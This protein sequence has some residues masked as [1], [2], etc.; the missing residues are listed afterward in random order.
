MIPTTTYLFQSERLG[1][2]NWLEP[3]IEKMAEINADPVVMEFFPAIQTESQTKEFID[4][5]QKQHTEK[6]FC[7]FAVDRLDKREFIGFIGLSEQTFE[8][9]F[10]PCID[11]GWRL[12]RD[13]WY[14]GFATEG[15]KRCIEYAFDD[16]GIKKLVAIAPAIN[17]KS[18]GVMVKIGMTKLG[19]FNHPK[20]KDNERLENCVIYELMPPNA[21]TKQY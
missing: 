18:E 3:D 4:K 1:F 10:S 11:I 7:Y 6:G 9:D 2:R 5:M 15:A 21:F 16:L 20:L 14:N 17:S 8:A 13:A 12:K 19:N